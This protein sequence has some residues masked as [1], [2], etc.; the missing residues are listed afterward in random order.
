VSLSDL[1]IQ[2]PVLTLMLTL[3]LVVFGVLGYLELGV[4]QM[5]NMEFP[6]VT[7]M[8]Q[9][10][11][12]SPETMEEDVTEVL[13][14]QLN[15][16]GGLRSLKSTT[17]PGAAM[18]T[19]E[20]EL[21]RDIDQ[22]A[23]DV[24]DKVARARAAL[25]RELEPPIIDKRS[26]TS[27]PIIWLPLNSDRSQVET[28]EYIKYTL[29][30]VLETISGVA[31]TEIFG[32]RERAIR[33][34]IDGEALRARGLSVMD[35]VGALQREHIDV[36]AG[37]LQS[38]SLEYAL[39]TEAEFRSVD[40]LANLI[41]AESEGARVRLSDVA[42]VEDGAEDERFIARF[43]GA[44]GAGIGILKQSRANTVE[45][46]NR[47]H[48]QIDQLRNTLPEGLS[49]PQRDQVIDFSSSIRESVAETQFA[50]V[51]GAF[52]ATLTVL[53]FLRRVRPTLVIGTSIPLSLIAAF[54]AM[55]VFG[56]TIN[57]MTLLALALAVGVVIDDA[58]IVLENIERRREAGESPREAASN[59]A[60]QIAFAATAATLSIAIVFLPVVF[61]RGI[62]GSFLRDFG[63]TVAASVVFSLFVALTLIPMLAARLPAEEP[64]AH[65]SLYHRLE[66]AFQR[67]E[68]AYARTLDWALGHRGTVLAAA[69]ASFV[70]ALGFGALLGSEFFPPSD[71]GRMFV[72]LETP[73]GT[74][75]EGTTERVKEAEKWLMAQPEL[76]GLF[77]GI[78]VSGPDG[79]GNVTNAVFVAILKPRAER[80]RSAQELMVAARKALAEIPGIEVRVF[81]PVSMLSGG[82][83]G[84]LEFALRGNLPIEQ[85]DQISDEIMRRLAAEKGFVDVSK[86]LRVGLPEVRVIPDREKCA[87]L[88][89]DARSLSQIVQAGIGGLD[90][91]KF[92][93]GGHRYDIRVRLADAFRADPEAIGGLFVRT[94]DGGVAE[95][96]NLA[97]IETGAAASIISRDQRQR[98]VT[99]SANLE[100]LP[101]GDAIAIVE[102]VTK[103][104]L[105]EGASLRFGGSAEQ[106]L[107]SLRQFAL[108]IGLAVLVIY[109]VL[110][111][112]F[113]SLLHPLTVMLA[114]PLAMV[115]A[116]GGLLFMHMFRLG[117]TINLFSVIGIILLMGLVTKNSIL[118]VDFANE[119]RSRGLDKVAAMREA[120]PVRMRP[121]LMTA[122][123]MMLGV[124]PAALGI[125]PGAETRAPMAVATGAGMLSSVLL[126]LVVVPVFYVVLDDAVDRLRSLRSV[127][128]VPT[129]P[130]DRVG[131]VPMRSSDGLPE[132]PDSR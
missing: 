97:R 120:A 88:G 98:S 66:L 28:T 6:V 131:R 92:K 64:H 34:W 76:R 17:M 114:L 102:R 104:L 35:V 49:F 29:K 94:R 122:V 39:K 46:A 14:E 112:Q 108:A 75:L 87:A 132:V 113:E 4:D 96:R 69:A 7:V 59:G 116:F 5:P 48:E 99:I 124:L 21:E 78:G 24:R 18:I 27:S 57:T 100:G 53:L 85:L 129:R 127:A 73:P 123:S 52:L 25:P 32:K 45:I 8:A 3:S 13:E 36:P 71:E 62:V 89:V 47:T 37:S 33:I 23:Q 30:P 91:A 20:F 125:G 83:R 105:P 106:F 82:G 10:E 130:S 109:M 58:I 65:G 67:I 68:R 86:S 72:M 117:M 93:E 90:V 42:R 128:R 79:P 12:A 11:G 41:V 51:F 81:D 110:A 55:W 16:I 61:V 118:L 119:L 40:E 54:G 74:S 38:R 63:L 44:P 15:T 95:L 9:M 43:N 2:R 1:C 111:A 22:A 77:S 19:A 107:Q 26:L 70:V 101:V 60:R 121:V 56:L 126:T 80:T 84:E 50:L 103:D 31:S 115:G